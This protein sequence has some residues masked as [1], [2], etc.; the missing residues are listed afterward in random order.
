M[1]R[2]KGNILIIDDKPANLR[3]LTDMLTQTGH[4]VRPV[5]GGKMGLRAAATEPPDLVLLDIKMPEMDGFAVCRRFKESPE[6]CDIPIIFIS[7][8]SDTHDKLRAFQ[9]GAVDYVAKPFQVEEVLARVNAHLTIRFLFHENQRYQATLEAEVQRRTR[10]AEIANEKLRSITHAVEMGTLVSGI[11]HEL[12]NAI[13]P[14]SA[15]AEMLQEEV[16]NLVRFYGRNGFATPPDPDPTLLERIVTLTE[17][18]EPYNRRLERFTETMLA[19]SRSVRMEPEPQPFD[20][21][22][23]LEDLENLVKVW[24]KRDGCRKR[25]AIETEAPESPVMAWAD[26]EHFFQIAANLCKNAVDAIS[27]SGVIR[28]A[29]GSNGAE[30]AELVVSDTGSGIEY[31]KMSKIFDPFYTTKSAETGT[32]LGLSICRTLSEKNRGRLIIDTR[33]GHGTAIRLQLPQE[34]TDLA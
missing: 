11:L 13:F 28:I 26:P 25:I 3:L 7:A 9:L 21:R 32:G 4:T 18:L 29:V 6:L 17:R 30:K 27:E 34:E 22:H 31:R 14:L 24:S 10:E 33:P 1:E 19:A 8:H 2:P 20:M 16:R 5:P 12:K 15:T 23:Y